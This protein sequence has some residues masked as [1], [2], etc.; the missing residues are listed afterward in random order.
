MTAGPYFKFKFPI[1][2]NGNGRLAYG[3]RTTLQRT[4]ADEWPATLTPDDRDREKALY[5]AQRW[6][7]RRVES[8]S[9]R[10]AVSVKRHL[11][12]D[13]EVPR[14]AGNARRSPRHLPLVLVRKVPAVANLDLQDEEGRSLPLLTKREN[15]DLS[16]RAL[17]AAL[18]FALDAPATDEAKLACWSLARDV[19]KEARRALSDLVELVRRIPPLSSRGEQ[20]RRRVRLKRVMQLARRM[21]SNSFVWVPNQDPPGTRRI[22]KFAYE[23]SLEITSSLPMRF[24]RFI[25]F[26]SLEVW[27]E[28]PHLSGCRSYHF[29][30]SVPEGLELHGEQF[31]A[32]IR[33]AFG[34][35]LSEFEP[36]LFKAFGRDLHLYIDLADRDAYFADRLAVR[37]RPGRR[38]FLSFALGAALLIAAMLW[39]VVLLRHHL[40]SEP[41]SQV[42][43][44]VLLLVPA[45]LVAL[46]NRPEEHP[47]SA[48]LLTGT[49]YMILFSGV[50]A[51]VAAGVLAFSDEPAKSVA[52]GATWFSSAGLSS[53]IAVLVLVGWIASFPARAR[54]L[55]WSAVSTVVLVG[56]LL[57]SLLADYWSIGVEVGVVALL[58]AALGSLRAGLRRRPVPPPQ[59][60]YMTQDLLAHDVFPAPQPNQ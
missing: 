59:R 1:R 50:V 36:D 37:V 10:D 58:A 30:L 3:E 48:Y 17:I 23:D 4:L 44:P 53:L 28:T 25:G 27:F 43:P 14:G 8:V 34:V 7:A 57:V 18:E 52:V 16:A 39:A 46:V 5:L 51:S 2:R 56:L 35:R 29:E 24:G 60:T 9:L 45:V 42:I 41:S 55:L 40:A 32:D 54:G 38:G 19:P 20:W 15:A 31:G 49:R 6:I 12:V 11:T 22:V 21:M 33:D 26:R 47:F 13:Y